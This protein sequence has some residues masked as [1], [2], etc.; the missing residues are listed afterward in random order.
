MPC[1]RA[2]PNHSAAALQCFCQLWQTAQYRQRTAGLSHLLWT[3]HRLLHLLATQTPR[4]LGKAA[5]LL[6]RLVQGFAA[7]HTDGVAVALVKDGL[8]RAA[9]EQSLR[10]AGEGIRRARDM[11]VGSK[12]ASKSA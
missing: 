3:D 10:L 4:L 11:E 5:P 7:E 2:Y 9:A 1:D 8:L 6:M 12:E